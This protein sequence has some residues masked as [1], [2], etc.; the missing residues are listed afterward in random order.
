MKTGAKEQF[1]IVE[2]HMKVIVRTLEEL[3]VDIHGTN[4]VV[5]GRTKNAFQ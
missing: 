3:M 4:N 5:N 1:Y 2:S